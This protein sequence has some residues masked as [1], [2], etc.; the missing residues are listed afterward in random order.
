M[1]SGLAQTLVSFLP[2]SQI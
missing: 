1:T 2:Q